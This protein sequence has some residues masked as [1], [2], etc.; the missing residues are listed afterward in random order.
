MLTPE[1]QALIYNKAVAMSVATAQ[2]ATLV[3]RGVID[4]RA[5]KKLAD[6]HR[7]ELKELLKEVG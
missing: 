1:E 5:A 4:K 3:K 6:K 7:A 2:R